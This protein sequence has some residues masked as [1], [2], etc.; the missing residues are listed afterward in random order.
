VG[1]YAPNYV[2]T[3]GYVLNGTVKGSKDGEKIF[4]SIY[5]S[6]SG[7][8]LKLKIVNLDS[9]VIR[10]GRFIFK[11]CVK[12]PK[13]CMILCKRNNKDIVK[14][15]FILENVD[16]TMSLDATNKLNDK[17][18]GSKNT[19][20]FIEYYKEFD[21]ILVKRIG[22]KRSK[23]AYHALVNTSAERTA[24]REAMKEQMKY[25][26]KFICNHMPSWLGDYL[27][28]V[29][30]SDFDSATKDSVKAIMKAKWPDNEFMK[31]QIV[32]DEYEQGKQ[33]IQNQTPVGSD[34]KDLAMKDTLGMPMKISDYVPKNKV[35]LVDFWASW[36]G[37]C[38][39]EI[40]NIIKLYNQY[41][42]NGF[43]VISI[44]FDD[45]TKAWKG[46]INALHLPWPQ[47]SDLKGWNSEGAK[48]YGIMS[49]P[50]TLLID[51]NGKILAKG[52]RS[53]ELATKLSEI[54]K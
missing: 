32:Q 14:F 2:P 46:A 9:A 20:L 22:N 48:V 34:Y 36:C 8:G 39:R 4:I 38:R 12:E 35:T 50:Y 27:L 44:S 13:P 25:T 31:T 10:N 6:L 3:K 53:E 11:G 17:V 24:M 1:G 16:F 33:F 18:T 49:I 40:S 5:S 51:Q 29:F 7:Q 21:K 28:R 37:P 30:Y 15:L 47:M 42:D 45:N 54:L 23:S 43:G 41:K 26:A 19:D 52:L